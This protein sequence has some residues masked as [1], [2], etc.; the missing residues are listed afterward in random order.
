M[1]GIETQAQFDSLAREMQK[2]SRAGELTAEQSAQARAALEEFMS[3][4]KDEQ[5]KE[6]PKEDE[7]ELPE[8]PEGMRN[9]TSALQGMFD[10]DQEKAGELADS[11]P[12]KF[13]MG[14]GREATAL[15]RGIQQL[16]STPQ[17][18]LALAAVEEKDRAIYEEIDAQG[19]GFE[20]L[21]Q[22]VP[23][24]A[25]ML[26]PGGNAVQAVN[27][28]GKGF[29]ALSKLGGTLGGQAAMV[30]AVEGAK[31]TTKEESRAAKAAAGAASTV[32]G[33]KIINGLGNSINV[34]RIAAIMGAAGFGIFN[35]GEAGRRAAGG[36]MS[37]IMRG[38]GL[39]RPAKD[40]GL[41]LQKRAAAGIAGP[42]A[43][44]VI[45]QGGKAKIKL[46]QESGGLES[47]RSDIWD[48]FLDVVKG[49]KN[50]K[51]TR[52]IGGAT[53]GPIT[54]STRD[55]MAEKGIDPEVAKSAVLGERTRV[56]G[57]LMEAAKRPNPKNPQEVYF[58]ASALES[59]WRNLKG[60]VNFQN[61]FGSHTKTGVWNP[62]KV[63]KS[64]DEL[65]DSAIVNGRRDGDTGVT[66]VVDGIVTDTL[67]QFRAVTKEGIEGVAA[68]GASKD[69][70]FEMTEAAIKQRLAGT[71]L[72]THVS[73]EG[74]VGEALK[75]IATGDTWSY[76]M[77]W[78][79]SW[80]E[81]YDAFMA[82]EEPK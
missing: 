63:A 28:V 22:A 53:T 7:V 29:N 76:F 34:G 72:A 79:T 17:E 47:G 13:L 33:G 5:A 9:L 10:I 73:Q 2:R 82:G 40:V 1:A 30:A 48:A 20:D 66:D 6:V 31:A 65:V 24:M 18:A 62:G 3:R 44:R 12:S 32:V 4:Q 64:I 68:Q 61:A 69:P 45:E 35:K 16:A 19:I 11:A 8:K 36:F 52:R 49:T 58:D 38:L 78:A 15:S 56:V 67:N 77:D 71:A 37:G 27:A 59:A 51:G 41:E 74:G 26:S 42:E 21:G 80:Q 43:K 39:Q 75:G 54:K 23:I 14:V 46:A 55:K 70:A 57:I 25:T 50:A 81:Q 60:E